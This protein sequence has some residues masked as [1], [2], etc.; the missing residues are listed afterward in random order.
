M[1]STTVAIIIQSRVVPTPVDCL[2]GGARH[3]WTRRQ[4]MV[5]YTAL[6]HHLQSN[7][8]AVVVQW[9][10]WLLQRHPRDVVRALIHQGLPLSLP[11]SHQAS[12]ATKPP[13]REVSQ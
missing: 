6:T 12:S 13:K 1:T 5:L 9:M 10:E 4:E 7:E 11:L 3:R 2:R 8:F